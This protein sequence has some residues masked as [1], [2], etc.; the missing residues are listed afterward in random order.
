MHS[1]QKKKKRN[2]PKKNQAYL[3]ELGLHA[4]LQPADAVVLL[5]QLGREAGH[6]VPRVVVGGPVTVPPRQGP[7]A[8][9][10]RPAA[11]NP[12]VFPRVLRGA[13]LCFGPLCAK[14]IVAVVA[15]RC[16]VFVA[17]VVVVVVARQFPFP[18]P[19]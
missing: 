5:D 11:V 7:V 18:G 17:V 15:G 3:G 19:Q 1:T 14:C 6:L 8:A 13:R 10:P 2:S 9:A 12:A 16:A 4:L